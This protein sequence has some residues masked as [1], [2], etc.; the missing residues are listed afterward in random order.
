MLDMTDAMV[1]PDACDRTQKRPSDST[2]GR[3]REAARRVRRV[4]PAR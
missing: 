3:S 4:A 2:F 1:L